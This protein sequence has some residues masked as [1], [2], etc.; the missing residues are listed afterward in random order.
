MNPSDENAG[1]V[2]GSV[3]LAIQLMHGNSCAATEEIWARYFPRLVKVALGTLRY[4]PHRSQDAND[5][6]QSAF[7]SFWQKLTAE[8]V[9]DTLDRNTLWRLLA[10]I[11]VRKA[12][13]IVRNEFAQKRGGGKVVSLDAVSDGHGAELVSVHQALAQISTQEFDMNCEENIESLPED[14]RQ[15]AVLRLLGH[16]N[17]EISELLNCSQRRVERKLAMIRSLWSEGESVE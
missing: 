11:T 8:G 16:T 6:A 14:L 17:L 1:E 5:A 10:T 13:R 7:I 9:A 3:S 2:R 12:R 4:L 15:F